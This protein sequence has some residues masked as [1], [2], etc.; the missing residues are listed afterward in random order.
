LVGPALL[1]VLV[2]VALAG[3]IT[4]AALV[5]YL[6]PAGREMEDIYALA[7]AATNPNAPVL[8]TELF[9]GA[10]DF[11]V[12]VFH[13]GRRVPDAARSM[14]AEVYGAI[15]ERTR[16]TVRA[17]DWL[18]FN[19]VNNRLRWGGAYYFGVAGVDANGTVTFASEEGPQWSVCEEPGLVPRFIADPNFLSD[20]AARRIEK[21]W[22][23]GDK[24]IT[25][26]VN[27]WT[28]HALW[29]SPTNRNVWIK[30]RAPERK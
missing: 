22:A 21:P 24:M 29:G 2:G 3:A 9:L 27:G 18:V 20:R 6:R 19:V 25:N 28:G 26:Q 14:S 16:V 15:G 10:D 4:L 11:V 7:P 1:F 12:D 13:N 30:F 17:G 8:A 5:W 23:G